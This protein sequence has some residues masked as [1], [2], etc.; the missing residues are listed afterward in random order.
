MGLMSSFF[1]RILIL[2]FNR[3]FLT[4][5]G[6]TFC[7]LEIV[8]GDL[9]FVLIVHLMIFVLGEPVVEVGVIRTFGVSILSLE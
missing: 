5:F 9:G 2:L 7:F 6:L 1:A 4:V 3:V 8:S